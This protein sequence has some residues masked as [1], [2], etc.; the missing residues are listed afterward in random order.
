MKRYNTKHQWRMKEAEDGQWIRYSEVEELQADLE[1]T[2]ECNEQLQA[3]VRFYM[4]RIGD[5]EEKARNARWHMH[6]WQH[7]AK[8]AGNVL[9]GLIAEIAIVLTLYSFGL[10]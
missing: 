5:Y 4:N 9:A 7:K 3:D 1:L 2:K 10:L 6:H 8:A